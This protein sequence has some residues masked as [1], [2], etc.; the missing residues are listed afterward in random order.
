MREAPDRVSTTWLGKR[1]D[2]MVRKGPIE[3]GNETRRLRVYIDEGVC[4]NVGADHGREWF[5][6]QQA[7]GRFERVNVKAGPERTADAS[8]QGQRHGSVRKRCDTSK[9]MRQRRLSEA[10][11][12]CA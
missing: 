12:D 7:A 6:G 11:A 4:P 8:R 5:P 9:R 10:G 3:P 1:R 2:E